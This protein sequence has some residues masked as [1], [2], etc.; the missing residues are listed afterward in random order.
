MMSEGKKT[1]AKDLFKDY[2]P[3]V[4]EYDAR[5]DAAFP[6][7]MHKKSKKTKDPVELKELNLT[8]PVY[9]EEDI[10]NYVPEILEYDEE[11]DGSDEYKIREDHLSTKEALLEKIR[12]AKAARKANQTTFRQNIRTENEQ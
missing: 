7:E 10:K 6:N 3:E 1:S 9:T 12:K 4:L 2:V 11:V 8:I 5:V